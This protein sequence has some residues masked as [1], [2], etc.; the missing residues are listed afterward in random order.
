MTPEEKRIVQVAIQHAHERVPI[1]V[2]LSDAIQALFHA[3]DACNTNTH[4][5]GGCGAETLHGDSD[6]GQ[7]CTSRGTCFECTDENEDP[8]PW[9]DCRFGETCKGPCRRRAHASER[10][11]KRSM[12]AEAMLT[13][14]WIATTFRHAL[15]S[16]RLR[17]GGQEAHVLESSNPIMW[18]TTDT[19]PERAYDVSRWDREEIRLTLNMRETNATQSLSFNCDTEVEILCDATR[20]AVLTIQEGMENKS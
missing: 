15:V 10:C 17:L 12:L 9:C 16:D 5:C 7:R 18:H 3:C 14:E 11:P 4:S 8:A 2:D 19:G 20:R 1:R 6:C 13:Q